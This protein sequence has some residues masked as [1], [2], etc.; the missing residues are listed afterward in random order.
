[1]DFK[2]VLEKLLASFKEQ[3]IRYALI[4]GFAFGL[5]G[6]GRSTV[7]ID[8]LVDRSDMDK[9]DTTMK[10]LG[11]ECKYRSEN[12][13]QYVSP[14]KVFGEVDFLHA[15]REA[16]LEMLERRVAQG[17]V[18]EIE[19][20]VAPGPPPGTHPERFLAAVLA[21]RRDR[22]YGHAVGVA[23]AAAAE[24]VLLHRLPHAVPDPPV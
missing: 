9:V 21:E 19:R 12:V 3:G 5:R 22:E 14:L 1:M 17:R 23:R 18:G 10:G 7:D 24:A 20:Y 8:F 6:A 13:S 11:Y 16:S 4:G 15:F 2:L